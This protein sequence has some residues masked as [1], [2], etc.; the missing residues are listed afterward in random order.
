LVAHGPARLS[1]GRIVVVD[2]Q[3]NLM[4]FYDAAGQLLK[5]RRRLG[6]GAG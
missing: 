1:D 2:M 4:H 3:T 5:N 6:R